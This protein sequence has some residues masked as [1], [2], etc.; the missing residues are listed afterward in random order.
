RSFLSYSRVASVLVALLLAAG[1]YLITVRL[2]RLA[3]LWTT[4]SGHVLL[5]K[6]GLVGIALAWGGLH[7]LVAVPAVARGGDGIFARLPRSVLGESFAGMAVLL[8]AA[9]L[10]DSKPPAPVPQTEP[11]RRA[12]TFATKSF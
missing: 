7:R 9:V 5:V 1:T 11:S 12:S 10:V 6:L 4:G 3:D 2:P 8:V